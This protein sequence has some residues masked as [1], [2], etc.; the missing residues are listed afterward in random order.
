MN[1]QLLTDVIDVCR[2]AHQMGLVTGTSGNASFIWDDVIHITATGTNLDALRPD[3][4]A[5]VT[6]E[7]DV[8]EGVP[9]KE[10]SAH[11][12]IYNTHSDVN[13]VFHLHGEYI[14]AYTCV[15][16]PGSS[17]YPA[18]GSAT[19]LKVSDQIPLLPYSHTNMKGDYELFLDGATESPVFLQANHGAFVGAATAAEALAKAVNL[20]TNLKV[21]FLAASSGLPVSVLS[22]DQKATL[23]TRSY[24][25]N[26]HKQFITY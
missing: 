14:A 2:E 5:K 6:R 10:L 22:P 20:E 21:W 15:G 4:F 13:S 11:R 12:A 17:N 18:I 16:E 26:L 25:T 23:H 19:P 24:E 7:G 9:S 3:D 8:I 1:K